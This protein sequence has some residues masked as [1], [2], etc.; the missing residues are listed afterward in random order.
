MKDEKVITIEDRI[1]KLKEQRKQR[2]NRRLVF[3][4]SFFF[5]LILLVI[6]FQSPLSH[7]KTIEIKGN[8]HVSSAEIEEASNIM[9]GTSIWNMD[10]D[11]SI[12]S[13]LAIEEIADAEITRSLPTTV[14]ITVSEHKR[15]AYL[16]DNG[17]YFPII[18]TG[19]FLTELPDDQFPADA[20]IL[21]NWEQGAV[22]EEL[23][24]E[25]NKVPE[26][27][28]NRISEIY[29]SPNETD[30]LRITLYMN[31]GFE[32]HTTVRNFSERIAPYAS[33]IKEINPDSKGII[34]MRMT[35]YFENYET[36]EETA[37]EGDR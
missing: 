22:V 25:L 13:I 15:V 26:S 12:E 5:F 19:K 27:L 30:P 28:V 1:P 16:H 32:V 37:S 18:E 20:P 8:H 36:E 11:D 24:N 2:A 23:A 9:I 34:H 17:K 4:L 33:I 3:F 10:N 29:Y 7:I 21:K 6:Y 14:V 31:D 35:P